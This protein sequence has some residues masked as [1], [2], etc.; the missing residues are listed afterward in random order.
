M[1]LGKLNV[2]TR[3]GGFF[4]VLLFRVSALV[5]GSLYSR[6]VRV[7][8]CRERVWRLLCCEVSVVHPMPAYSSCQQPLIPD[9]LSVFWMRGWVVDPFPCPISCPFISEDAFW[10]ETVSLFY[11]DGFEF[12]EH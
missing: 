3:E 12:Y 9:V 10:W 1:V 4:S 8:F 7:R 6:N 11:S 2:A 5:K